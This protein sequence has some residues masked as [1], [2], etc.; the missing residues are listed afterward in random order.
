MA[1][2]LLILGTTKSR[3]RGSGKGEEDMPEFLRN[4]AVAITLAVVAILIAGIVIFRTIRKPA[5][6]PP[7]TP[8][9]VGQRMQQQLMEMQQQ[10]QP[11]QPMKPM[12][13]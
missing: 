3:I 12:G 10:M 7:P 13:Q 4:P 2:S 11:P 1:T 5:A 9:E 6:G 8:E